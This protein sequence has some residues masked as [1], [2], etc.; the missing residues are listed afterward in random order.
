MLSSHEDEMGWRQHHL[1]FAIFRWNPFNPRNI[2][3]KNLFKNPKKLLIAGN[4]AGA[5]AVPA[6]TDEILRTWY[7]DVSDVTLLSD[8][9][10]LL[11]NKWEY[12][13]REVWKAPLL[14]YS[15]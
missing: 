7:P 2:F 3:S 8:S 14:K 1:T 15:I 11:Y 12:T 5:F 13:A 4:S 9:A 6:L 10:L